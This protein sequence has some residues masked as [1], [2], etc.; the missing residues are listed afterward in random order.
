VNRLG[1]LGLGVV[2]LV[3]ACGPDAANDAPLRASHACLPGACPDAAPPPVMP[4]AAAGNQPLEPWNDKGAGPLSGIFASL[5]TVTASVAGIQVT[6]RMLFRLRILQFG[7][8][9]Q[10]SN[11]LCKLELPSVPG[12]ATLV[13]P[14]AL[15]TIIQENSD[16]EAEGNYL[17]NAGTGDATYTPPSFL[18]VLGAKLKNP[19]TDALPSMM[20]PGGAYDEDHD[21]HPGVTIDAQVLTCPDPQQLYVALRTGGTVKGKVTGLG[22]IEGTMTVFEEQSVLGYSNSCLAAAADILIKLEP[23][24]PYHAVRV[25]DEAKIDSTGNVTCSDIE[26]MAPALFGKAWTG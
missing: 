12:V 15:E 16:V 13:I 25:A 8:L 3:A 17:S 6:L 5:G 21:G 22:T 10:Q 7:T 1:R 24:S 11:T 19:T 26:A 20:S 4:D 9:I 18:L 23:G 2:A 14:P